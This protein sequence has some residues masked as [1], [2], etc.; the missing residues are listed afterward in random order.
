MEQWIESLETLACP[1][2]LRV[3]LRDMG[4]RSEGSPLKDLA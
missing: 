3:L 1:F 4:F 2:G